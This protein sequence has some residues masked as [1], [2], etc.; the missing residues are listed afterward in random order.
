MKTTIETKNRNEADAIKR[1]LE[2]PETRAF[3]VIVG[4]LLPFTD[5][6]RRRVLDF[7]ADHV[8]DPDSPVRAHVESDP[9]GGR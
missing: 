1:A 9:E 3:V 2:D 7:V 4:T 8:S 6:A 5:R